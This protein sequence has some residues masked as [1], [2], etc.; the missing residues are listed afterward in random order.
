MTMGMARWEEFELHCRAAIRGGVPIDKIKET[1]LQGA[2]YCGV[3][4]ANTAFK[5]TGE[6]L[7]AEGRAPAAQSLAAASR[8]AA[9]HTF[10][11]PQLRVAVQG[12]GSP[13][14]VLSHA[15]GLDLHMWDA[16]A[17]RLA[18]SHTVLR[19]DQRG[20]GGSARPAGP[21][22]MDEL[23]DDAARLIREW[24]R[25]PGRVRRPVDGRHGRAGA[26]DPPPRAAARRSSLANTRRALP[27]GGAADVGG[28]D[29]RGRAGRHGG[30]RRRGGRAL[31][32]RRLP[33]RAS[34]ASRPGCARGCCAAIP[35]AT[36]RRATRSPASTGSIGWRRCA[37]PTLVIAGARDAGAT[38]EMAKAIAERIPGAEL[39]VFDDAS[40]LSVV[41]AGDEFHGAVSSFLAALPPPR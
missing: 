21:Y 7:R 28:A 31:P 18:A 17:A 10:S 15:L 9:H 27:G 41:E 11:A 26:R 6:I 35:P 29:R 38:P 16:L 36:S 24:G 12:A 23:V 25:G 37:C 40:H 19:Y 4:A 30:G 33:R 14:V 13:P 8:V 39:R 22:A 5:L 3:P 34:G 1:L 32:P 20:H 2:I